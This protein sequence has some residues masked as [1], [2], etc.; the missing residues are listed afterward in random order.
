MAEAVAEFI[1]ALRIDPTDAR[2]S[3]NLEIARARIVGGLD[4]GG[5]PLHWAH[6]L[7]ELRRASIWRQH[8][9]LLGPLRT[10]ALDLNSACEVDPALTRTAGFEVRDGGDQHERKILKRFW[11]RCLP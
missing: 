8:R 4:E 10:R 7:R 9:H 2:A 3:R 11:R 1:E 5:S 6:R